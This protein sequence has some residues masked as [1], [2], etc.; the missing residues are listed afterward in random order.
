MSVTDVWG[1]VRETKV[2]LAAYGGRDG[3]A[4]P[5]CQSVSVQRDGRDLGPATWPRCENPWCS[6]AVLP[7][8]RDADR[9]RA[10]FI[11]HAHDAANL[12]ARVRWDKARAEFGL[13]YARERAADEERAR[14]GRI[15]HARKRGLC[16]PCAGTTNGASYAR[17]VKHRNPDNCPYRKAATRQAEKYR[18]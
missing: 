17:F 14:Q 9:V 7:T 3:F 18:R 1:R 13:R 11:D 2:Y 16:I 6:A 10:A 5:F 12:E 4:C 8:D 15:E